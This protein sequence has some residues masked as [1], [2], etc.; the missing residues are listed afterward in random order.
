MMITHLNNYP[1]VTITFAPSQWCKK[2]V[3]Q[4]LADLVASME[5]IANQGHMFEMLIQG[6]VEMANSKEPPPPLHVFTAVIAALIKNRN[7]LKNSLLCTAIF[8]PSASLQNMINY[9]LSV[10]T[11]TRPLKQFD[12]LENAKAWILEQRIIGHQ[13]YNEETEI[14]QE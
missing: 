13:K 8:A 11:P 5:L 4:C 6:S 1:T 3:K 2:Q 10:Y 7:L 14:K 9:V 12:N